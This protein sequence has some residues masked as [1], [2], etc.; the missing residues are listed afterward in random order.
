MAEQEAQC[1]R[2]EVLPGLKRLN[3]R[4]IP[5]Q[6]PENFALE[7]MARCYCCPHSLMVHSLTAVKASKIS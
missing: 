6:A 1:K 2:C 4:R 3:Q 5:G 7:P